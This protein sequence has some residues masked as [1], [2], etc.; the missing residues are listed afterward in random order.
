MGGNRTELMNSFQA[1]AAAYLTGDKF[2]LG[3]ESHLVEQSWA[4]GVDWRC[5]IL[6][7]NLQVSPRSY[8]AIFT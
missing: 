5:Q 8:F 7:A 1:R 2:K 6:I 4:I 3:P